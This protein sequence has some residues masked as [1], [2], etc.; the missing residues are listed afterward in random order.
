MRALRWLVLACLVVFCSGFRHATVDPR[1]SFD[2]LG[3]SSGLS[4]S[5][6]NCILQD[7][8]GFLWIGTAD[9]LNR[10]DGYEIKTYLPVPF[11]STSLS[12]GYVWGITEDDSGALWIGTRHGGMNRMDPV[13]GEFQRFLPDDEDSTSIGGT[14][15]TAVLDDGE[16]YIWIASGGLSRTDRD[17]PGTFKVFEPL[18][19]LVQRFDLLTD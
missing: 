11:D 12:S 10:Y 17:D 4:D 7:H 3:S 13:T 1:L 6:I 8:L 19:S 5:H 2:R 14:I 16:K 15:A 9:G 18:P